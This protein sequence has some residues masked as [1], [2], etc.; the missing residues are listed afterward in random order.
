LLDQLA[1]ELIR[2]GL[3]GYCDWAM[4]GLTQAGEVR[5]AWLPGEVIE[6]E[7]ALGLKGGNCY[8]A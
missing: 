4:G 7:R 8:G 6:R 3:D 5:V 1:K 2:F